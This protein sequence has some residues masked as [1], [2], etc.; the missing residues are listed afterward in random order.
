MTGIQKLLKA[1]VSD[2]KEN[3]CVQSMVHGA[4]LPP[5]SIFFIFSLI[6][7]LNFLKYYHMTGI[8]ER[9]KVTVLDF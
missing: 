4:F 5:S 1:T 7:L 9:V 6:C 8:N 2:F 3:S